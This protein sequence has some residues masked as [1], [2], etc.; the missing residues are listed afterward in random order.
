[1]HHFPGKGGGRRRGWEEGEE[2]VNRAD[3]A[4]AKLRRNLKQS[5]YMAAD[6]V[7][8]HLG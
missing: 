2:V 3:G 6:A 5:I 8:W 4:P 7:Y 1:M